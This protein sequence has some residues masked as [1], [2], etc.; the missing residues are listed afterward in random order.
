[1]KKKN[2]PKSKNCRVQVGIQKRNQNQRV[3]TNAQNRQILIIPG[4]FRALKNLKELPGF[5]TE[6]E[7]TWQFSRLTFGMFPKELK[8]MV[9][10]DIITGWFGFF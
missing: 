3:L 1:L 9:R 6:P 8:T 4:I 5:M 7:N 2:N 10:L